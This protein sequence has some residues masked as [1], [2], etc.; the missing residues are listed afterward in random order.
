MKLPKLQWFGSQGMRHEG[1]ASERIKVIL[2]GS[3]AEKA[4]GGVS[5]V[6]GKGLVCFVIQKTLACW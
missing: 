6:R 3:R 1:A 5:S 4:E 2:S